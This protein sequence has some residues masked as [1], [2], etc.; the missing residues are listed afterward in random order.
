[1][2]TVLKEKTWTELTSCIDDKTLAIL[3]VGAIEAHG[4][5]LPLTT[6][7]IISE[8][9]S[10]RAAEKIDKMGFNVIVLPVLSYTCAKFAI[11]FPGT[12]SISEK[13]LTETICDIAESIRRAGI[14]FLMISSAHLDPSHISALRAA[15][16]KFHESII[17]PD[18]TR[19][20]IAERLTDEFKRGSCH[21]GCFE[22]SLVLASSPEMVRLDKLPPSKEVNLAEAISKGISSFTQLGMDSAYCGD[23]TAATAQEGESTYTVLADILAEAFTER[24]KQG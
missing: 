15:A 22:T 19:R 1:M 3:P 11:D 17:F 14:R 7:S 10:I 5:H 20:R 18:L 6:D 12:I 16:S 4:P 9:M 2:I 8:T 24:Y 21:A 23:P 13:T